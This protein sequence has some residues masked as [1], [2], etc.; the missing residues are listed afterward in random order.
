MHSPVATGGE[1]ATP[2]AAV[3]VADSDPL[4]EI[5]GDTDRT[6]IPMRRRLPRSRLVLLA[7][8]VLLSRIA[9]AAPRRH[10]DLYPDEPATLAMAR[11]LG[12]GERWNMFTHATWQPGVATLLA[13]VAWLTDDATLVYRSG[14]WMLA[15]VAAASS[16]VLARL[17]HRLTGLGDTASVIVAGVVALMPSAMS[18]T[19]YVWAEAP[20]TLIFLLVVAGSMRYF[21][22]P[23]VWTASGVALLAVLGY[24]FHNRL[25]PLVGLAA[26]LLAVDLLRRRRFGGGVV[27][28][29]VAIAGGLAVRGYS[30]F[31]FAH[32]WDNPANINSTTGT[33]G[34]VAQVKGFPIALGQMWYQLVATAGMF[35]VGMAACLRASRHSGRIG[36][37]H[38]VLLV[39]TLALMAV[40]VV[41]LAGRERGDYYI[42]G[43]YNDAILW[44]VVAIGIA[45]VLGAATHGLTQAKAQLV[46]PVVVGATL[47][48]GAVTHLLY[49]DRFKDEGLVR[50][51]VSGLL[52]YTA[53]GNIGVALPTVVAIAV[54]SLVVAIPRLPHRGRLPLLGLVGAVLLAV[55]TARTSFGIDTW[56]DVMELDTEIL[57]TRVFIPEGAE[58]GVRWVDPRNDRPAPTLL[59]PVQSRRMHDYQ[60]LLTGSEVSV[61]SAFDDRPD[62]RYVFAYSEDPVMQAGGATIV[63]TD[64]TLPLALWDRGPDA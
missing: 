56:G 21:D 15:G 20:V 2:L 46:V 41:F 17:V 13:P 22:R 26:T 37:D 27:V 34:R 39:Y 42:Y 4:S 57:E 62:L 18:A 9:F 54:M 64:S 45:W 23:S 38:R 63:W 7:G 35:G 31:V 29:G 44:P 11:W 55:G 60:F 61:I 32:V 19:S 49:A 30:S 6:A 12:G 25:L 36:R 1:P 5:D 10:F 50:Q 52:G 16:V 14:L 51:M 3:A 59:T 8:V 58:Y 43:R 47:V 28:I 33:V 48:T 24:L 53:A 40:S